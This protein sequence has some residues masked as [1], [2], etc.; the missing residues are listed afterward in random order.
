[1]DVPDGPGEIPATCGN[2][3][4]EKGE[5]C[6][7]ENLDGHDCGGLGFRGGQLSCSSL[8]T[9]DT[10]SCIPLTCGNDTLDDGE[11]CDG[12]DL[13][14]QDCE[15]LG[16]GS[17]ALACSPR[18]TFDLSGCMTAV[19]GNGQPEDGEECDDGNDQQG[20]G[21]HLC[22]VE[23]GWSC[24]GSPSQCIPICGDGLVVGA[25]LCDSENLN[26]MTCAVVGC[27]RGTALPLCSDDCMSFLAEPCLS[28]NDEDED[29]IDD[30]CDNCP[31]YPNVSQEDQDDDGIGDVCE[32]PDGDGILHVIRLFDSF[33]ID[34][35]LWTVS[36]G[37]WTPL[38]DHVR[39]TGAGGTGG[40]ILHDI[41]PSGNTYSVE[42]GF[43]YD[44]ANMTTDRYAGVIF[45]ARMEEE[46][47][48][49]FHV[50]TFDRR[51]NRL[52]LWQNSAGSYNL[53]VS[54]P[55]NTA[56]TPGQWHRVRAFVTQGSV[57]LCTY[58]DE[59]GV[60]ASLKW[61]YTGADP[62]FFSGRTG[63]RLFNDSAYFLYFV[64]YE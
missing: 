3:I 19:C 37:T 22:V 20:D 8:C 60:L 23:T 42:T 51:N 36:G 63:L 16:H 61:D 64:M 25:E 56:A 57:V 9:F 54:S 59:T 45:A 12:D 46:T 26:G 18:C 30:H 6:D 50:C 53:L 38:T 33:M 15:S 2:G 28:G 49:A 32:H 58:A 43:T 4:V 5:N 41:V 17:G 1:M 52:T 13:G 35:G 11:D 31:S 44:F 7:G 14:G 10:A 47:L 55:V 21:C 40:N 48:S 39:G 27:P 34:S 62:D 29:G 24:T